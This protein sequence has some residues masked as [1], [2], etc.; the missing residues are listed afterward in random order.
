MLLH[1]QWRSC[2]HHSQTTYYESINEALIFKVIISHATDFYFD[3]PYEPDPED[4]GY[5]WATRATDTKKTFSYIA[6]NIYDN[7]ATNSLGHKITK[8][9]ICSQFT[10]TEL[11]AG[12]ERN[13]I[14]M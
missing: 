12:K 9:E 5:Y 10:C 3:H 6:E 1:Q 4:R 2:L 11:E 7:I 13:V 14:G 8:S